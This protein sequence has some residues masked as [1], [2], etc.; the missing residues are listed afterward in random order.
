MW[1]KK[2]VQVWKISRKQRLDVCVKWENWVECFYSQLSEIGLAQ[3]L[4]LIMGPSPPPL[5][6]VAP[7]PSA[8]CIDLVC[9]HG[10]RRP[11]KTGLFTG[12]KSFN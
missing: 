6:P 9:C 5:L 1:N 8:D 4:E 3:A 12:V 11:H 2:I 10:A 7:I